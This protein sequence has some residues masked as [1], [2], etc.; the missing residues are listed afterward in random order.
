M[1]SLDIQPN[2]VSLHLFT[3]TD[4]DTFFQSE[5]SSRQNVERDLLAERARILDLQILLDK[6]ATPANA[7]DEAV[8]RT[9]ITNLFV[10]YFHTNKY[11]YNPRKSSKSG[12]I[13]FK[14]TLHYLTLRYFTLPYIT[15]LYL[16]L[17]YFTLL[18]LTSRYTFFSRSHDVLNLIGKIL[19]FSEEQLKIVGLKDRPMSIFDSLLSSVLPFTPESLQV[20]S[21]VYA[22]HSLSST[23][24]KSVI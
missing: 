9:L 12:Q 11:V 3:K 10:S 13:A 2:T 24:M 4:S 21:E 17:P 18:Y 1:S 6:L 16:T 22:P 5:L 23:V 8:D 15:L 19:S 14:H 20:G 7:E